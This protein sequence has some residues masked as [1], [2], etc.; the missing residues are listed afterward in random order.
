MNGRHFSG[1]IIQAF[2]AQGDEKFRKSDARG[3][4]GGLGGKGAA[5]A[6]LVGSDEEEDEEEERLDEF[7]AWLERET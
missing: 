3:G 1:Q 7:G 6:G 4:S 5:A 2:I